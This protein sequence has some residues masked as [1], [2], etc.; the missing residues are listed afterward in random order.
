MLPRAV[1]NIYPSP[2]YANSFKKLD[3]P[4]QARLIEREKLF[5]DNAYYPGLKTHKLE[6]ELGNKGF[7]AYYVD[8]KIRVMFTFLNTDEVLYIDVGDHGIYRI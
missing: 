3:P 8:D 6:G 1:R 4:I 2:R 7:L 5:R